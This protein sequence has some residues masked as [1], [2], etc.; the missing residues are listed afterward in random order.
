MLVRQCTRATGSS[1]PGP[2]DE[3]IL[4]PKTQVFVIS[5]ERDGRKVC[6]R[7]NLRQNHLT[8]CT[9]GPGML[10]SVRT[11]AQQRPRRSTSSDIQ[12]VDFLPKARGLSSEALSE[13]VRFRFFSSALQPL[14]AVAVPRYS[15]TVF[16]RVRSDPDSCLDRTLPETVS[17]NAPICLVRREIRSSLYLLLHAIELIASGPRHPENYEVNFSDLYVTIRL[18]KSS[19]SLK[20]AD[21]QTH[22][23][24]LTCGYR[25]E[26]SSHKNCSALAKYLA[27]LRFTVLEGGD[28]IGCNCGIRSCIKL[29]YSPPLGYFDIDL[30]WICHGFG[31]P[32]DKSVFVLEKAYSGLSFIQVF[33]SPQCPSK[34]GHRFKCPSAGVCAT[35]C[36]IP[37]LQSPPPAPSLSRLWRSRP[38][39]LFVQLIRTWRIPCPMHRPDEGTPRMGWR[40][41]VRNEWYLKNARIMSMEAARM[42][43]FLQSV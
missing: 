29:G 2:S 9:G 17:K 42:H 22:F 30:S 1:R 34:E 26:V 35:T 3:M 23:G 20:L 28:F 18:L 12:C 32:V 16:G 11:L 14:A 36:L 21:N 13:K 39:T 33:H 4:P 37:R 31:S 40:M 6:L 5:N 25:R 41:A 43:S 7:G 38:A 24:A 27:Q 10:L 15:R 19:R 8:G